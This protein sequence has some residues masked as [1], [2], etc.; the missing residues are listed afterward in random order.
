[1][2]APHEHPHELQR[3]IHF[4]AGGFSY[5]PILAAFISAFVGGCFGGGCVSRHV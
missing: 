1:M 3:L 4:R 2:P 5:A